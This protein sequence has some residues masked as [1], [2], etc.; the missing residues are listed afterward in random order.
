MRINTSYRASHQQRYFK[1]TDTSIHTFEV[2]SRLR[3]LEKAPT[4]PEQSTSVVICPFAGPVDQHITASTPAIRHY[5]HHRR[6]HPSPSPSSST[7]HRL[8]ILVFSSLSAPV[9]SDLPPLTTVKP[10]AI[11][12]FFRLP[13]A[14]RYYSLLPSPSGLRCILD[15]SS[16]F[17]FHYYQ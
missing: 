6:H 14:S 12:V 4:S 13:C 3:R 17:L 11:A 15:S 5:S 1:Y 16:N 9:F 10:P 8:L 7:R 2:P